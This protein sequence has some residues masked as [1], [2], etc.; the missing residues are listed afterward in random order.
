M[1]SEFLQ[2][3]EKVL[4]QEN[5]A[6]TAQELVDIGQ[7]HGLFSDKIAGKTPHQTMKSK[8][9]THIRRYGGHSV[10]VRTKP[11][12]F[13]LRRLL[14][15]DDSIYEANPLRPPPEKRPVLV[16]R[17]DWLDAHGRFQGI[18]REWKPLAKS[19]FESDQCIYMD[20]L[21]AESN[22]NYKQIVTYVMVTRGQRILAYKRG[23][24]T[25]AD[26]FLRGSHCIGFGGHVSI[27]DRELFNMGDFGV[28]ASAAREL[29]EELRV[30]KRDAHLLQTGSGLECVGILNDDSTPN[31]MRHIAFVYRFRV[32]DDQGWNRPERGEQSITQLR[33]YDPAESPTS[34]SQFE[35]WS[36][37]CLR[38]FYARA[39]KARPSFRPRRLDRLRPPNVMAV[40]GPVGSGKSEIA[41]VLHSQ[42]GY[43]EV[44]SGAV[45]A[46]QISRP[47]VSPATR[48]SFQQAAWLFINAGN[49]PERLAAAI[50]REIHQRS[51]E[52]VMVDGIRQLETIEY[53]RRS[54]E[55][56]GLG[57]LFVHTPFDV[58]YRFFADRARR[59]RSTVHDF[60]DIRRNPVEGEVEDMIEIADAVLYNWHGI[61]EL[62][63]AISTMMDMVRSDG[64]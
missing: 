14:R 11:G 36:Q 48:T 37:L 60:L 18:L 3:A 32:S 43:S 20:R 40:I 44:N 46:A 29:M 12:R 47:V 39:I 5:R 26:A 35:Y 31:G 49:G 54:L 4:L 52:L 30:P 59:S 8:L 10:F 19:L 34:I 33:W 50:A 45:L 16:F 23:T 27:D 53:L 61:S 6:L 55:P 28:A 17:S 22:D 57:I 9:S 38:E 41:R 64:A 62:Q 63:E 2:V 21:E 24:Y 1:R 42:Y 25:R 7:K 58:A 15:T 56:R 51:S 13:H